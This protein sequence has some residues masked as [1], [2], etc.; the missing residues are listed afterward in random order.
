MTL[1]E[2]S[3]ASC[4]ICNIIRKILENKRLKGES[5]LSLVCSKSVKTSFAVS[6]FISAGTQRPS[7]VDAAALKEEKGHYHRHNTPSKLVGSSLS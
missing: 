2:N 6:W 4:L 7:L 3:F 1:P 5:Y